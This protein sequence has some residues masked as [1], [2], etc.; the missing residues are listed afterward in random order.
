MF[1]EI[2]RVNPDSVQPK[3]KKPPLWVIYVGLNKTDALQ[4]KKKREI[5]EVFEK[6]GS[7]I[8]KPLDDECKYKDKGSVFKQKP[9]QSTCKLLNKPTNNIAKEEK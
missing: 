9:S 7:K 2:K 6:S 1:L 8:L 3:N 4:N 5:K